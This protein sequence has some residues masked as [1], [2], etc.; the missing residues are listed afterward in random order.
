VIA[1]AALL[2]A[3]LALP[4]RGAVAISTQTV[5]DPHQLAGAA[6]QMSPEFQ[7]LRAF[8]EKLVF[9]VAWGLLHVGQA[10]LEAE[11]LVDF[12]GRPAYHV[13]SR[14]VSNH[15][16]DG[17]YKVRDLN[18]SWIDAKAFAS[19]GYAKSLREGRFFREEWV[20]FDDGKWIGKWAGRDLNYSVA[21]GTAPVGVHDIL[22][23]LYY[24]RGKDLA[25]GKDI[26]LD[27]NTRQN[28]ALVVRV[29]KKENVKTPAGRFDALLVE[30]TLRHE[31]LFIQKGNR[32]RI[33]LSDDAKR[34]P[35]M[36]KVDVFFGSITARLSKMV[37]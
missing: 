18:E 9:E 17:F 31:G 5:S 1:A 10:T 34:V 8:P 19:L 12:N 6:L 3:A 32:L 14:A 21:A 13:V 25:V 24:L 22:S 26:V 16:C 30:P 27:V 29:I 11:D 7:P 35:V 20:L 37:Y 15:F 4:A 28:W 23:S 33:W 36:M 2:T